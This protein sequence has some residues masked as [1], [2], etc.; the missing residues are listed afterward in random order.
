MIITSIDNF[1]PY[2]EITNIQSKLII[3]MLLFDRD[4]EIPILNIELIHMLKFVHIL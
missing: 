3:N 4:C 2:E 1:R